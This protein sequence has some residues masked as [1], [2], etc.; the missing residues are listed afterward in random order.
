MILLLRAYGTYPA[1]SVIQLPTSAES[2]LIAQNLASTS[3]GPVTTGA[4]TAT[5]MN[6]G[7]VAFAAGAASLT[8]THA[9]VTAESKVYAVVAQAAADA[10]LLRV[11]RVLCANGSFTIYGTAAA[12][13]TTTVDWVLMLPTG[14]ITTN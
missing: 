4:V 14:E 9:G 1:G 11:E 8:V 7:R 6:Q 5:G 10:T 13:A 2:A 12:T 3:A